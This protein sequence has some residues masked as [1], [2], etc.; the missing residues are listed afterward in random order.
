LLKNIAQFMRF[1]GGCLF[2]NCTH[3]FSNGDESGA[4]M[5]RRAFARVGELK[6]DHT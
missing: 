3:F 6:N 2:R 5:R 1:K 4:G